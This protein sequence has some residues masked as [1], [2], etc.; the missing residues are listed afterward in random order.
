MTRTEAASQMRAEFARS[1]R[2]QRRQQPQSAGNRE[3]GRQGRHGRLQLRRVRRRQFAR[4]HLPDRLHAIADG[5]P[6]WHRRVL[7]EPAHRAGDGA[8]DIRAG[9]HRSQ[10]AGDGPVHRQGDPDA[11]TAGRSTRLGFPTSNSARCWRSSRRRSPSTPTSSRS[12]KRSTAP[13]T[14]PPAAVSRWATRRSWTPRYGSA[15]IHSRPPRC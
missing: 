11:S 14:S 7:R 5:D 10:H 13:S 6:G 3:P 12:P 8:L 2:S 15:P 1:A 4:R 9:D